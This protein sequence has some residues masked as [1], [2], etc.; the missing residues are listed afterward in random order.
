MSTDGSDG[1][2]EGMARAERSADPYWWSC[3]LESGREIALRKPYFFTDDVVG[4]CKEHHPNATTHEQRAIGPLMR[5]MARR[6]IC[7]PTQDW[8]Q[9][10]QRQNHRRPMQV[11]WSL[12]YRGPGPRAKPRRH[13][14][15]DPRQLMFDL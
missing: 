6:E 2:R 14:P 10:S 9:S 12:I 3:M 4:W 11:W 5:E 7:E 13:K 1:K 8:V 15:L